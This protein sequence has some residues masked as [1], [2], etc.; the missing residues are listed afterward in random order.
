MLEILQVGRNTKHRVAH[1]RAWPLPSNKCQSRNATQR[2]ERAAD[3][4]PNAM[5]MPCHGDK[6][7]LGWGCDWELIHDYVLRR[8]PCTDQVPV[9]PLI[10]QRGQATPLRPAVGVMCST[11][12]VHASNRASLSHLPGTHSGR[13]ISQTPIGNCKGPFVRQKIRTARR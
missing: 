2:K 4:M 12:Q 5:P 3:R 6:D 9:R 13:R 11:L 1:H 8:L 10:S 7:R